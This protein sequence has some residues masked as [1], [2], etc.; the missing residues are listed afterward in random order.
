MATDNILH[1][2][3]PG[4]GAPQ[5]VNA[6]IEITRGSTGKYEI[7]K[8]TGLLKLDR[9]LYSAVHYPVNYGFIPQTHCDDGDPLDI[10]VF[11]SVDIPPLCLVNA[12][13][14]GALRM[15]DGG[16][17]DDK[18]IAVVED[19]PT[20]AHVTELSHIPQHLLAQIKQ[21]LEDYKKLEK[22]TVEVQNFEEKQVA[23]DIVNES[24]QAYRT[25]A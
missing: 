18:I 3:P 9:V 15:I 6:I 22:K 11:S 17:G 10:F 24:I 5:V 13:V 1:T 25:K 7:D 4:S 2:V 23:F 14:V 19:D 21:F 8:N 12:R 16:E 20:L